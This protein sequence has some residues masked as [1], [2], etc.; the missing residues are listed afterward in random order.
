MA[1]PNY[2][3]GGWMG[4]VQDKKPFLLTDQAFSTLE[5]AYIW[6][7][8]VKKREGLKLLGRLQRILVE[9]AL[10][11][12][13]ASATYT[14]A[15]ILTTLSLRVDEPN[16][17][18]RPGT[19]VN[20][21][22]IVIDDGGANET[23][24]LDQ[25][26]DGILVA[27]MPNTLNFTTG[28][29]NY[30]TGALSL[31]FAAPIPAGLS[32]IISF[33]YFPSLP[34]MGIWQRETTTAL[35]QEQTIF[36]DTRYAYINIGQDQFNE[37]LPSEG[38]TWAGTDSDFFWAT[39]YRGVEPGQRF[40]FVTN[41]VNDAADPI[42]YTDGVTWEEFA[43]AIASTEQTE[44][45]GNVVAPWTSFSGSLTNTPVVPGSVTITVGTITFTDP[46]E[47]GILVGDPPANTGTIDYE[48][49]AITL[50]FNPALAMDTAVNAIY[51]QATNQ[52]FQARIL[53]PYYGRLVALNV[54]EGATIATS[55]HIPNRARF[56]QVGNPVAP[57]AWRTDI[58][59]RG[60]FIDA[61]VNEDIVSAEFYKDTLIVGFEHS[62]WQLRY[63]GE[64]GLP[65]LWERISS[66]FGSESTFASILFDEG[67]L[68]VG[69][70][71]IVSATAVNAK[72]IDEQIPD[73]VF[74][75]Q[76]IENGSK[77]VQGIR[78]FRKEV[79]YWAYPNS[80]EERKFPDTVL[81]FNYKNGTY[82]QFRDSVT[83]LGTFQPPDSINW[84]RDDIYWDDSEVTWDT[85]DNQNFFPFVVSG[86]QQGFIHYYAFSLPDEP[87]L[88]ITDVDLSVSP[89]IINVVNHNLG[90]FEIIKI[91]GLMYTS[92][93]SEDLNDRIF[94][95]R[96]LDDDRF[97]ILEW[98]GTNY[99]N[100]P[101]G[102]SGTYIGGGL[103]TLYPVLNVITKDFNPYIAQGRQG[104][105]I[106]VD[107]L[108]D[109]TE[110]SQITV[111][112]YGNASTIV[113]GNMIVGNRAVETSLPTPYYSPGSDYAWHRFSATFAA[114][115]IKIQ[116]T[117]GDELMN[118][119]ET[120]QND[121]ILNALCI[122][123]REGSRT[124]Y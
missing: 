24:I 88:S 10:A 119:E 11:N 77:R 93:A 123:T 90:T 52:L 18:I 19:S 113:K 71:A 63:V 31:T 5:N 4:L 33:R 42:R 95:V 112:L 64:Y 3:A 25:N 29:I 101:V 32:V 75:I 89:N 98:D 69:D 102:T 72:R 84:D 115:F 70:K 114:Q 106:Y 120:H 124:I 117:Y 56:S 15:D 104:K 49:G 26:G 97:E 45:L 22:T 60:G 82:S 109:A 46:E 116:M 48:T 73:I 80:E 36:W 14:D 85:T 67:V 58:F 16:A 87:S 7:E 57:D 53:I 65:F 50:T 83:C 66:D 21:I 68:Q 108:T 34:A 94:Q 121:W 111:N 41:F 91:S 86:N 76:N 105:F 13:A 51:D 37:F 78:D 39:N 100:T 43:P 61:P 96:K 62:T 1:T 40:F 8:R 44:N 47:D 110:D 103:I 30:I 81:V 118:I 38:V 2:I 55:Q 79:V 28:T 74:R 17:E 122:W 9:Q 99:V 6:R 35:K 54:W 20:P 59:G 27:G 92:S 107:F 12:T 23:L